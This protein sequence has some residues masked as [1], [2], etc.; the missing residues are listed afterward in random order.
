MQPR[1]TVII[2]CYNEAPRL[3]NI[4]ALIEQEAERPWEWL[5]VDDGSRDETAAMLQRF[6]AGKPTVRTVINARNSGKGA[7]VRAGMLQAQGQLVGYVDA[8]LAADPCQFEQFV[9]DQ[10]LLAGDEMVVGIRL[11]THDGHVKRLLYRHIMGRIFQ[12]YASMLTG[13][14]VYDT[15]CGFKLMSQQGARVLANE[16]QCDGFAFDVELLMLAKKRGIRLR[17]EMIAW[18]EQGNSRVR[19]KH[20]FRMALDI[21]RLRCRL[22]H[23][24]KA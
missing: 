10:A 18:Q 7:A 9:D 17:E 12:T 3:G 8:D 16:M 20:V 14:T 22:G 23:V 21:L 24:R 19:P 4:F 11:K 5:F 2:P 1:L 15:Q 13:L 6:A